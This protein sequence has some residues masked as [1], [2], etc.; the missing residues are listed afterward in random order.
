LQPR[1]EHGRDYNCVLVTQTATIQPLIFI[2]L[3]LTETMPDMQSQFM[4]ERSQRRATQKGLPGVKSVP[5]NDRGAF[6]LIE[7]L[8]VIG[9]IAIL[10]GL[11][12]PQLA[13]AKDSAKSA[14]CK[15]NLRQLGIALE[16]YVS[17]YGKY[18]GN[19]AVYRGGNFVGM[20]G[21]WGFTLDWFNP[22]IGQ[23]EYQQ[24]VPTLMG[25]EATVLNCPAR[26][27]RKVPG[28]FGM[29]GGEI[30]DPGYGYNE[31]GTHWQ[32]AEPQ[33]GLGF[34]Q[35]IN[36]VQIEYGPPTGP[37]FYRSPADIPQPSDMIAIGDTAGISWLTPS[38]ADTK[39][40]TLEGVHGEHTANVA[41]CDG[42]V[43]NAKNQLWN[44][45]TE[46]A[47]ARWNTDNLPHPETW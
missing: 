22:Y 29:P 42:H 18:P 26:P 30:R 39:Q 16:L 11:L 47:R 2:Y 4:V 35:L 23:R 1:A 14:S 9:I 37:R 20:A 46:K 41:L 38:A 24:K 6:T 5:V 8:V 25:R 21:M 3:L 10:A 19:G 36:D 43:E 27:P 28:M 7:L 32:T 45:P 40:S 31:L 15:S 13:R 34:I 44:A 12:L 33:L 17:D